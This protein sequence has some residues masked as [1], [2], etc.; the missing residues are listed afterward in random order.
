MR[1]SA[2]TLLFGL[3]FIRLGSSDLLR[4]PLARPCIISNEKQQGAVP[5]PQ[6]DFGNSLYVGTLLVGDSLQELRMQFDT[7]SSDFW[8][9]GRMIAT[10]H[11]K[12]YNHSASR[13]YIRNGTAY[14]SGVYGSG[15]S[16]RGY[17]STLTQT[18]TGI[19]TRT[20][21]LTLTR[22][23]IGDTIPPTALHSGG[24]SSVGSR[25]QR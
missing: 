21:T 4:V 2:A 7:G 24:S 8:V 13:S 15:D 6:R 16:Y 5:I 1:T 12:F 22:I 20:L 9:P 17:F 18:L 23:L 3:L 19:H 25:L 10:S 14:Y 11:K